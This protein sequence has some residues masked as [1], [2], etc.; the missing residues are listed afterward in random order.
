MRY[1]YF[2]FKYSRVPIHRPILVLE[3]MYKDYTSYKAIV[4]SRCKYYLK[5]INYV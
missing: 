5:G 1:K 3:G 2:R 4:R